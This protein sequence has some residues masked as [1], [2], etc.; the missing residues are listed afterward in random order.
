VR[1]VGR[2]ERSEFPRR[3]KRAGF[4]A[5]TVPTSERGQRERFGGRSRQWRVIET[6][7]SEVVI[8]RVANDEHLIVMF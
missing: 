5:Y 4:V 8:R 3:A 1:L 7:A 2:T 6:N